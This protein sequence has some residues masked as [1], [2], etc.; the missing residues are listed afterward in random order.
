MISASI[1]PT[2]RYRDAEAIIEWL[3]KAFG[4]AVNAK[5]SDG[6]AV[7]HAELSLGGAIIMLGEARDDAYGRMVGGPGQPGGKSTYAAVDDVDAVYETAKAAG[8]KI[9]EEPVDRDHGG[10]EFICAD[11]QGNVWSFG[12]YRPEAKG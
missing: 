8:A 6:G 10:R 11:P 7:S 12:T 2:F 1:H 4:F 3:E 9:L 5:Y